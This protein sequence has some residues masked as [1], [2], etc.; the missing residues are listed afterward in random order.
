MICATSLHPEV[1]S[2]PMKSTRLLRTVSSSL[3]STPGAPIGPAPGVQR[4]FIGHLSLT[5][6]TLC[7]TM[8]TQYEIPKSGPPGL[9]S[10]EASRRPNYGPGAALQKCSSAHA[11]LAIHR[12]F[13]A[14]TVAP[15]S[16]QPYHGVQCKAAPRYRFR[17]IPAETAE[18]RKH[19]GRG[20][21]LLTQSQKQPPFEI[22]H[23]FPD[24]KSNNISN[25]PNRGKESENLPGR[26]ALMS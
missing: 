1:T 16:H 13:S 14:Y 9:S 15:R 7:N 23:I 11:Y 2:R 26:V 17:T 22:S 24:A 5:R 4:P 3:T 12:A 20:A 25:P 6:R 19:G 18:A 21:D 8:D 10:V